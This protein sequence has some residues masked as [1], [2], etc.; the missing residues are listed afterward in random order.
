[1]EHGLI[2]ILLVLLA[3]KVGAE[4]AERIG[5]PAVIGEIIAG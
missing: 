4:V 1:V 5:V 3:A 2:D